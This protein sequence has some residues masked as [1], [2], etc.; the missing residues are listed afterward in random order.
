MNV[1]FFSLM[2]NYLWHK[3]FSDLWHHGDLWLRTVNS[4][5]NAMFTTSFFMHTCRWGMFRFLWQLVKSKHK[6][7]PT[8]DKVKYQTLNW[9]HTLQQNVGTLNFVCCKFSPRKKEMIS[10]FKLSI[11]FN[12][13]VICQEVVVTNMWLHCT[14]YFCKV[15]WYFYRNVNEMLK[16]FLNRIDAADFLNPLWKAWT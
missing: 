8:F 5:K 16:L 2:F 15:N 1:I 4:M 7:V 6:T 14:N 9:D 13:S 3:I 10:G 11:D 12:C